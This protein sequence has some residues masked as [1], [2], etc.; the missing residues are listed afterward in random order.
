MMP[1]SILFSLAIAAALPLVSLP[2]FTARADAP[3]P[4][5]PPVY[6]TPTV[7]I[8]GR[9]NKP[10]VVIVVKTPTAAAEA[11]AAHEALRA[12]LLAQ[13]EPG[14]LHTVTRSP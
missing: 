6:T 9:P 2:A 4:S 14:R 7:V 10:A 3:T 11:G 13:T 5:G 8:Y 12:S 1:R